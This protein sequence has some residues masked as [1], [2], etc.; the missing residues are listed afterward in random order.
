MDAFGFSRRQLLTAGAG[1]ALLAGCATGVRHG[2]TDSAQA[3]GDAGGI[4]T[5]LDR[6]T[7]G[8]NE[9]EV[10]AAGRAGFAR[11]LDDQLNASI[12]PPLAADSQD[13]IE[14]M[15]ISGTTL[16]ALVLRMEEQ[17]KAA[18]A[19]VGDDAK[20]AAQQAYQQQMNQLA[21]EAASR[22]LLRA[23]YSPHQVLER[24]TWF[25]LNHFSVH[26]YKS[27]LRAMVADY[28]DTIRSRAL[29]RFRDLL[30]A[31][32]RHPAMLRYLDN[33]QNAAG[34][35]NENHAR[36]LMEL[37]TLGVDAGY[38][39]ADVQELAR[40]LTGVGV[41]LSGS[42]PKVRRE[43]QAFYVRDGLFEFNP[44]RHDFGPK[45]LLGQP[46]AAQGL[47]ELDE[48]LDRLCRHPAA[49][50]FICRKLAVY[51]ISDDPPPA[52]VAA[53]ARTF[54]ES[55]GQI[56]RVLEVLFNAEGF[57]RAHKFKDPMRYVTSAIRA[58]YD[59]R[60]ILN[61]QPVLGWLARLGEPLYGRQTPDG[62][63][64]ES[65]S[66]SSAGQMAT[67]FE[68]SRAIGSASAGLFRPDEPGARDVPAFPQLA[69]PLYYEWREKTLGA[70]TRTA[71]GQATSPQEWNTFLLA[72]PEFMQ[73]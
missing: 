38:T 25:W 12:G 27:N 21:R 9:A 22:H 15:T 52:V 29:G 45:R 19:V 43:L 31:V 62:Y 36:E 55:D 7:W 54:H 48:A 24:M 5:R 1:A 13:R 28:D 37:H 11:Y 69:T 44:N 35:I 23:L 20:K 70:A 33:E 32:A 58:A 66:W 16:Q 63:P 18:D 68:I 47:A 26:Q 67:R 56:A 2:S 57:W 34:H 17:R 40:V 3:G 64:L 41:N 14:R 30:G 4:A 60:A 65:R 51:W 71:L 59:R 49:A 42:A 73:G 61:T 50:T 46:I 6:I 39:Q 72:S 8:V 53:M 10:S